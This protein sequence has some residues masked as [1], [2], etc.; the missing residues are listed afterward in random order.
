MFKQICGKQK[1]C[2]IPHKGYFSTVDNIGNFSCIF[3][4]KKIL[5]VW[6][7]LCFSLAEYVF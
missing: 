3:Y 5:R 6:R 4:F 1:D 7:L 2:R